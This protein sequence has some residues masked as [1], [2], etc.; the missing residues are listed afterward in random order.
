MTHQSAPPK[1]VSAIFAS[2]FLLSGL[3]ATGA[4]GGELQA[5]S[6]LPPGQSGFVGIRGQA[7]GSSGSR[8]GDYGPHLDDQRGLYWNFDYKPGTFTPPQGEFVEPRKGIRIYRDAYGVPVIYADTVYDVWFGAGFAVARDRLF[9][10]DAV[11]R[12]GRGTFAELVGCSGVPADIRQRV[13]GYTDTEYMEMYA[14]LSEESQ[15]VI[16][17]YVD[18]ANAWIDEVLRDPD[19]IPAEYALLSTI[20]EPLTLVDALAAGVYITRFVASEGGNDIH[21]ARI[22]RD[23]EE[24]FGESVGRGIFRDFV[25]QEDNRA[26]TTVARDEGLFTNS[27]TPPGQRRRVFEQMADYAATLPLELAEGPGTGAA[28]SPCGTPPDSLAPERMEPGAVTRQFSGGQ[29]STSDAEN[30]VRQMRHAIGAL[31]E[32]RAGLRGGS[33]GVAIAPSHTADGSALLI[34]A[35]QLGYSYPSLLVELEIHGAGYDAR[36]VSVPSLPT[37]GIGYNADVAWALTTGYS[38]TI[39]SYIETVRLDGDRRQYLFADGWEDMQCRT[40]AVHYRAALSGVPVSDDI[41]TVNA[42]VCRTSHGPVVAWS[43][44]GGLARTHRYA[45]WKQELQTIEGILAWNRARNLEEFIA[46][47]AQVT[48][49]ENVLYAGKDGH[50][51]YFHP[52]VHWMRHP[53]TDQRL[54]KRGTGEHEDLGRIPFQDLPHVIDPKRG[55]IAN[56]NNKPA[57]GWVDGEGVA[58]SSVPEGPVERVSILHEALEARSDWTFEKL[59]ELDR[60]AGVRDP[61]AILYMPLVTRLLKLPMATLGVREHLALVQ[62]KNWDGNHYDA[63]I[64]PEDEGATDGPGATIFDYLVQAIRA[65]LFSGIHDELLSRQTD[66]GRHVFDATPADNLALR[67]LDP[68]SSSLKPSRDYTGNRSA[69]EVLLASLCN[70]LNRLADDF[71]TPN[72]ENWRRVHP[73]SDVCS[74]TGGVIGPCVTMPYVDRGSWTHHAGF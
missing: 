42:E 3:G 43:D 69:D 12:T 53:D 72:M 56:W 50:I 30:P 22:L 27:A 40:E 25:W 31:N 19:K 34:S 46:G 5:R 35:P 15:T 59:R 52:G 41:L 71:G 10:M 4:A 23:L 2:L 48:W 37:V 20:P 47:V 29:A 32:W 33:F 73:R 24:R 44:D 14:G 36:G 21:N 58:Y 6:T 45:M 63:S 16:A 61:R 1:C 74:L 62:L 13:T 8:P 64:N 26:V 9:L 66:I 67:I 11:R 7:A 18:G 54:P 65:E 55:Y 17:A 57:H 39:D 60:H 49:N 68:S 70:A 38:K 28:D 51:A